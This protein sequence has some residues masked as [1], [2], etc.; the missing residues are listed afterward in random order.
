RGGTPREAPRPRARR[1]RRIL[2]GRTTHEEE[3]PDAAYDADLTRRLLWYVKPYRGQV[4]IAILLLMGGA[5][6]EMVGPYLTKVAIDQ[7]IP[8]C[9]M[10]QLMTLVLLFLASILVSFLLEYAQVILTTWIGQTVMYDLRMELFRHLQGLSLRFFD[11]YPVG[12]LMTR[13]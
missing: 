3:R 11:K 13:V 8:E 7:A 5:A 10:G 2:T 6:I 1:E 4:A 12:R 9:E